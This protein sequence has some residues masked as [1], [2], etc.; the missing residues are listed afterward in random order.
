MLE[1]IIACDEDDQKAGSYYLGCARSITQ[2]LLSQNN[3]FKITNV[4]KNLLNQYYIEAILTRLSQEKFIFFAFSHGKENCLDCEGG[5][6][7]TSSLNLTHFN[8]SFFYTFSCLSG[9]HLGPTLIDNG[10]I[11]FLGY[12]KVVH[13]WSTH[14]EVFIQCAN[15]GF[16]MMLQGD[17][18]GVAKRKMED[19][20]YEQSKKFEGGF[21]DLISGILLDNRDALVLNGDSNFV[22]S[23]LF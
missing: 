4:S 2:L 8:Q 9:N 3:Q 21:F 19:N 14:E 15:Y 11:S 22:L 20:Y 6:Y 17:S 13:H 7:L 12:N 23:N 16:E 5:A 18:A 10:C 1:V